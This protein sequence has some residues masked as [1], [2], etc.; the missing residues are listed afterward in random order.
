MVLLP[1][2]LSPTVAEAAFG[3]PHPG[4]LLKVCRPHYRFLK[5]VAVFCLCL[6]QFTVLLALS[7]GGPRTGLYKSIDGGDHWAEITRN[8]G[9]PQGIVGKIGIAVSAD[10]NRVYA[11]VE[12]EDGG[13]FRSEDAGLHWTRINEDRRL[14]QRAFYY[15]RITADP[16]NKDVVYI[17]NT[18]L[19]KSADGGKTREAASPAARRSARSVDRAERSAA[20]DQLER[21]RRECFG[22]R[23]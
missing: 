14:R 1:N 23:R 16:K 8:A 10:S 20:H 7:S 4:D 12:A 19:Y 6:A 11:L 21:R 17:M 22:Q 3:D 13:L 9:L 18:G 15:T 2:K 5:R